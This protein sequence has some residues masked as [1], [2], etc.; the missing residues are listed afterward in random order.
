[1][2]LS[3]CFMQSRVCV[4]SFAYSL[5]HLAQ[6]CRATFAGSSL[7]FF[8]FSPDPASFYGLVAFLP[9]YLHLDS[10][11]HCLRLVVLESYFPLGECFRAVDGGRDNIVITVGS[12][13]CWLNREIR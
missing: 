9:V 2:T 4:R 8:I 7:F 13:G 5:L 6:S 1:M 11:T 3:S 12:L 10:F